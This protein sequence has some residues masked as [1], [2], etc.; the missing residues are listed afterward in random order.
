[1]SRP[2][3]VLHSALSFRADRATSVPGRPP[4]ARDRSACG[5]SASTAAAGHDPRRRGRAR[6]FV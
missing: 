4:A 3:C 6:R 5:R 2:L 1:M